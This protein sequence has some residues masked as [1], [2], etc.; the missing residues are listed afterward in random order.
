MSF[1][2]SSPAQS[3]PV[4]WDIS[5]VH[6]S[7]VLGIT[8]MIW[9]SLQRS[10]A[11]RSSVLD[12]QLQPV[13]VQSGIPLTVIH[14]IKGVVW[15]AKCICTW[16]D[17]CRVSAHW[18]VIWFLK[19]NFHHLYSPPKYMLSNVT[20]FYYKGE[21]WWIFLTRFRGSLLISFSSLSMVAWI[22][23]LPEYYSD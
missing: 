13:F 4:F 17:L 9:H 1:T 16:R 6:T 19:G 22:L 15:T 20:H 10:P 21:N 12:A 5:S 18:M 3:F 2:T 8:A 23:S 14:V 11:Q 7:V